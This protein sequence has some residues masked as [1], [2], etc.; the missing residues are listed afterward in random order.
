MLIVLIVGVLML[1][2]FAVAEKVAESAFFG[3]STDSSNTGE[4]EDPQ[5]HGFG[6][7]APEGGHQGGGG[8]VP[9]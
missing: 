3:R 5:D 6:D 4:L 8:D 7:P 9:G 1:G 2:T